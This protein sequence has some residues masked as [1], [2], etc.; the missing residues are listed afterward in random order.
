M[1]NSTTIKQLVFEVFSFESSFG[2]EAQKASS[3]C[4]CGC[5]G[6]RT[7]V[8]ELA[9]LLEYI[10]KNNN[11]NDGRKKEKPQSEVEKYVLSL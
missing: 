3:V 6:A 7:C 4:A 8:L 2:E 11:N 1:A 9:R 5:A 10:K